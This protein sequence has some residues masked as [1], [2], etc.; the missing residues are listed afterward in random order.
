LLH[1]SPVKGD[2]CS[3]FQ[4]AITKIAERTISK[5]VNSILT[6]RGCESEL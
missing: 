1:S 5:P 6:I 3:P 4:S 2:S